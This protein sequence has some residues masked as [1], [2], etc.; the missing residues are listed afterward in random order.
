M[1]GADEKVSRWGMIAMVWQ[2]AELQGGPDKETELLTARLRGL[3]SDKDQRIK[4]QDILDAI[5]EQDDDFQLYSDNMSM[6]AVG[7][8]LW[9]DETPDVILNPPALHYLRLLIANEASTYGQ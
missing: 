2:I 9:T 4:A 7:L 8:L 3:P 1:A 6:F 5:P